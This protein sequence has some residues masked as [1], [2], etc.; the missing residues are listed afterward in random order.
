MTAD[1]FT[2]ALEQLGWSRKQ[3]A[4]ELGVASRSRISHWQ[5]GTRKVPEYI[6]KHVERALEQARVSAALSR[7]PDDEL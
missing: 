3:A 4:V 7:D 6:V 5:N 1:E 2:A